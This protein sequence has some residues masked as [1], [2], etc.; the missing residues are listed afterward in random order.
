MCEKTQEQE[1]SWGALYRLTETEF[2]KFLREAH[3]TVPQKR[4][5]DLIMTDTMSDEDMI[6]ITYLSRQ[7]F[8]RIKSELREKMA[9]ILPML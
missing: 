3:L 2:Q 9:K 8:Y 4:V 1:T 5:L 6:E 7:T